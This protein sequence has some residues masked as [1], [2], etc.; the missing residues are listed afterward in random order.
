MASGRLIWPE[1]F[2]EPLCPRRG[3]GVSE[4][5]RER[6]AEDTVA[7]E[8]SLVGLADRFQKDFEVMR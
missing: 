2:R 4:L 6:G 7:F 3:A 5:T 1:A 8:Q